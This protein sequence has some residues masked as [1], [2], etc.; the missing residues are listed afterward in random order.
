MGGFL[1]D[2]HKSR[3][4]IDRGNA[5]RDKRVQTNIDAAAKQDSLYSENKRL[6]NALILIMET[7]SRFAYGIAKE[8][9]EEK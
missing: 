8:A 4:L 9:L 5:I 6:R 1:D 3:A 7:E 2:C